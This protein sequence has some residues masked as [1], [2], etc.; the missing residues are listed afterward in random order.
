MKGN[1]IEA[2]G[3]DGIRV[4][5]ITTIPDI[6]A[7]KI[8]ALLASMEEF[9]P[10]QEA[11]G[12]TMDE[13]RTEHWIV[14]RFDI[15]EQ[16]AIRFLLES[17][18]GG[19]RP[20]LPGEY[21]RLMHFPKGV[22]DNLT[23]DS[24]RIPQGDGSRI[25]MSDILPEIADH[26][27]AIKA[28]RGRCLVNGLGLGVVVEAMLRKPEVDRVE[29][30]ERDAEV[31]QL[32]GTQLFAKYGTQRLTIHAYDAFAFAHHYD[33]MADRLA[34]SDLPQKFSVV[35]HDIWPD[36]HHS[37]LRGMQRLREM[38]QP[39]CAWQGCW[40]ERECHQNLA[41]WIELGCPEEYA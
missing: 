3:P 2:Q 6:V 37:N 15:T 9:R 29:V 18:T 19:S 21:R 22:P 7:A 20:V 13:G 30:V 17:A 27:D 8:D 41:D 28:A 32:V 1:Y 25:M 31:I 23:R 35:W 4:V 12:S 40:A 10:I 34:A 36:I 11:Y 24:F 16:D 38:Y 39:H 14:Q 26:M 5:E 33:T